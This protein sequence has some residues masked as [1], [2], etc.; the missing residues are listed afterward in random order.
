MSSGRG[1]GAVLEGMIAGAFEDEK[2]ELEYA[3]F[4][5]ENSKDMLE[6]EINFGTLDQDVYVLKTELVLQREMA[7]AKEF[8]ENNQPRSTRRR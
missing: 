5:R 7:S 1:Q 4:E 3:K 2:M 8:Q 6:M